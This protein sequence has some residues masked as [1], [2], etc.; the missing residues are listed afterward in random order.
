LILVKHV[1]KYEDGQ[2]EDGKTS[3]IFGGFANVSF[4]DKNEYSGDSECYV[5]SLVPKFR[6]LFTSKGEGGTS[7]LYMNSR[8]ETTQFNE[9]I[10]LGEYL[11]ICVTIDWNRFWRQKS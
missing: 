8:R 11:A 1:E 10:G 7:F 6:N 3:H 5:F 2:K 4:K 9:R